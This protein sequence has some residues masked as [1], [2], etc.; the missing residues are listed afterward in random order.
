MAFSENVLTLMFSFAAWRVE[1]PTT[2]C[3]IVNYVKQSL[4]RSFQCIITFQMEPSA[5]HVM[6]K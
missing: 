5:I 2:T 3:L 4:K 6:T 1:A